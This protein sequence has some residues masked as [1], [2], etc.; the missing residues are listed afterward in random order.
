MWLGYSSA[1]RYCKLNKCPHSNS[2][3]II[4]HYFAF[5]REGAKLQRTIFSL[6][7]FKVLWK[8]DGGNLSPKERLPR[9]R[10]VLRK[11]CSTK[12]SIAQK[13]LPEHCP[14]GIVEK[15]AGN[16]YIQ[17]FPIISGEK[18]QKTIDCKRR[19]FYFRHEK[20]RLQRKKK[21]NEI[22]EKWQFRLS[23]DLKWI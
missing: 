17:F 8:R 2:A 12:Y 19:A 16:N 13:L 18:M 11:R 14:R 15:Q 9:K 6:P 20:I 5:E 3:F 1:K 4:L 7:L 10:N 23:C 22:R 21:G